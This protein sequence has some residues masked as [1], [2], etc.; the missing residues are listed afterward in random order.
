MFPW[1]EDLTGEEVRN[2]LANW[3][4][5]TDPKPHHEPVP[6]PYIVTPT[7]QMRFQESFCERNN[8]TITLLEQSL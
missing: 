8:V 6:S 3:V 7:A 4:I 2:V 5:T 1:M